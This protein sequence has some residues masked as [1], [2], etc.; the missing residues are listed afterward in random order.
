M[1]QR[2]VMSVFWAIPPML[3]GGTAAAA[4]IALINAIGNLGGFFGPS[5]MGIAARRDRRLHRRPAGARRRA[6]ARSH[7]GASACGCRSATGAVVAAVV[8]LATRGL[9]AVADSAAVVILQQARPTQL[10]SLHAAGA[11]EPEPAERRGSD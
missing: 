7:A 5:I 2:S 4:G 11:A 10:S 3:L 1:G 8:A 6:G 9:E